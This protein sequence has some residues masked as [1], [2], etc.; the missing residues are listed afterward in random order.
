[1]ACRQYWGIVLWRAVNSIK[2]VKIRGIL[3]YGVLGYCVMACR[4]FQKHYIF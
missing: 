1:M 4:T 2:T 3:C